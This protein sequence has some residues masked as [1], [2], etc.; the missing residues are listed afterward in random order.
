MSTSWPGCRMESG[1]HPQRHRGPRRLNTPR[2]R[3]RILLRDSSK[4]GARAWVGSGHAGLS[5]VGHLGE[6]GHCG[7]V[8]CQLGA[9]LVFFQTFQG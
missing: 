7:V 3:R 6:L 5:L 8:P 9:M 2:G 4:K 1:L